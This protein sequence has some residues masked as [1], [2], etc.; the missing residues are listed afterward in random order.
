MSFIACHDCDLIHQV[1]AVPEGSIARCSRCGAVLYQYKR[2]S[3]E[4]TLALTVAGLILFVVAN[5]FP[6]L[7]FKLQ[8]QVHETVLIT[9]VRELYHQGMWILATV[10]LLT[11]IVMPAAQMIGLLY[12]LVPL[13]LNRIPWKLKQVF[14]FIQSL[15]PWAM[16]EVFMLGILVSIVKLAKMATIVPGIAVFAFMALIFILAACLAVLDPH[17]VWEKIKIQESIRGIPV[18]QTHPIACHTCHLLCCFPSNGG[19]G[20]T[21]P[22]CGT[23][24]HQRK[25]DSIARTWALIL[26]AAIFYIP[27]NVLPITI[28]TSLGK[29]QAD[30]IISGVMYFISSGM[31]PI[32][33]VIFVASVFVPLVKLLALSYLSFSVP[34]KSRWRPAD[35]TKIYRMAEVVGRWSMV[36]V[37]VVTILVAMVNLGALAT[38]EAGPAAVYFCGV[39]IIT[40]FAAMSFDPRL[41]WDQMEDRNE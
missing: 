34:R 9:G 30:T 39:V 4:R 2:D 1:D 41:I 18:A 13:R 32:A 40:M 10:V 17:A 35:R 31:W 23:H 22:R 29:K 33:L 6:F 25:P 20:L 5:S 38:I 8:A 21:C 3:L 14:R 36:D 7:G 12:V 11:T 26:G 37:Y 19:H 24:L 16:M 28:V 15:R 27:A